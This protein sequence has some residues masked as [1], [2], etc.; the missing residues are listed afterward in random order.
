MP[1]V[2]KWMANA[3]QKLFSGSYHPVKVTKIKNFN[4]N[5]KLVRFEGDFSSI[6]KDFVAGNIIEFRVTGTEFRHYTPCLFDKKKGICEVL[7]YLHN[8]GPGSKWVSKLNVNDAHYLLGPG[9][10]IKFN[11]SF[12]YHILFGD[13]TSLGFMKCVSKEVLQLK[14]KYLCIIELDEPH[15]S[16]AQAIGLDAVP[17]KKSTSNKAKHS[18]EYFKKWINSQKDIK[19]MAFYLTGNAKSVKNIRN[20]LKML[21]VQNS[22]IQAEPYWVE[23]KT[24]L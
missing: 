10:K 9:G 17:L 2:P 11:S 21:G 19:K 24:G 18:C 8:K 14:Q 5:L 15:F 3:M 12:S 23:G 13:E 22:Q 20:N 7:F 6:K 1:K 4:P 16:W